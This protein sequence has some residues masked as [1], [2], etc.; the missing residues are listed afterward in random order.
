PTEY[1]TLYSK[2]EL[3]SI[4]AVCKQYGMYLFIDG[5]RM[6]YG[7]GS[8]AADV[9]LTDIAHL[10]DVFYIGGTKCGALF[11]E[12]V[13]FTKA[14]LGTDF[15]SYIKQNGAMLA[16]GWLLGLQFYT[17]FKD[18]LYFDITKNA[19]QYA[20]QIKEAFA[21]KGIPA[22]FESPTNQQFVVIE[23]SMMAKLDGKY[24]YEYDH[25]VDD[26]H[27]CIRFC[28]SWSTKPEDVQALIADIQTL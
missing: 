24:V 13:V 28:T 21:A 18:G 25:K 9:T 19:V 12:A 15:R 17:L 10:A 11:G 23:N 6:G 27:S 3:E 20:M 14:E 16:K 7:L 8:P 5:A 22:Y 4:H 1:G 2:Q 26:T